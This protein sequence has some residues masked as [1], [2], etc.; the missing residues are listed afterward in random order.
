MAQP[1]LTA[2]RQQLKPGDLKRVTVVAQCLDDQWVPRGMLDRMIE[3]GLSFADVREQREARVR[4]EYYRSLLNAQQVVVNRAYL[5]NSPV[6]FRD[7]QEGSESRDAFRSMLDSGAILPFLYTERT[8]TEQPSF[9]VDDVGF[10]AW[11]RICAEASPKCVRLS[12]DDSENARQTEIQLRRRF[13][14][15]VTAVRFRDAKIFAREL[16]RGKSDA[17]ALKKRLRE[18]T[19][20]QLEVEEEK[21]FVNRADLYRKFVNVDGMPPAEGKFDSGKPFCA[22]IKQ[23]LDL[24]YNVN[25]PDALD[26]FA[27]TPIDSPPR[28][29]LQE[30]SVRGRAEELDTAELLR[31]IRAFSFSRMQEGLFFSSLNALRLTDIVAVRSSP[32]WGEYISRLE[33]LLHKPLEFAIRAPG[34]Y[35]AYTSLARILTERVRRESRQDAAPWAPAI[36]LTVNA[37]GKVL[38][39]TWRPGAEQESI[40]SGEIAAEV[41]NRDTQA[42]V[43][44]SIRNEADAGSDLGFNSEIFR[45][46]LSEAAEQLNWLGAEL[47]AVSAREGTGWEPSTLSFPQAA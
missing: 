5:Y 33:G 26:A 42:V 15:F 40:V 45:G 28:T 21:G 44:F 32:E 47:K 11:K 38:R 16:G 34:V 43:E 14:E 19:S 46:K 24:N 25:L 31:V 29:V 9:L 4:A 2:G 23:I 17:D 22:E 30:Y 18:L 10:E 6:V 1:D 13:N 27:L 3:D 39:V 41:G 8:P 20:F 37:A 35:E 36:D 12:W 7:Y